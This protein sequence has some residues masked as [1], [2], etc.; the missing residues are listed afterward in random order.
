MIFSTHNFTGQEGSGSVSDA[1]FANFL[2]TA[3]RSVF[4]VANMLIL[5]AHEGYLVNSDIT[6]LIGELEEQSKMILSFR[7][8]LKS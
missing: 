1:D 3:R 6:P 5:F 8:R 4:E 7:R 2:N